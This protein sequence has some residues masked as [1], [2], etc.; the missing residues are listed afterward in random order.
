MDWYIFFLVMIVL[1]VLMVFEG[2][3]VV[4]IMIL[5]VGVYEMV[6][7]KV[8]IKGFFLV[9]ILG[10]MI[11]ICLD[12]IGILIKNEMIVVD[13]VVKEEICVLFIMKNC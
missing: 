13:V 6:K 2:L 5:F 9:E 12:K 8:I 11:V 7:E 3:L 4:L 1:V 10:F